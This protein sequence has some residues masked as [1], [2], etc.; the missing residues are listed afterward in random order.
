VRR[1][2]L[3]LG[4]LLAAGHDPLKDF[5]EPTPEAPKAW[6][7]EAVT[8]TSHSESL[9]QRADSEQQVMLPIACSTP[10]LTMDIHHRVKN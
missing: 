2:L 1:K 6:E 7:A 5:V 9:V 10:D 4:K 3:G 8:K